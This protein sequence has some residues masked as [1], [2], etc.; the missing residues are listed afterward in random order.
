MKNL[1]KVLLVLSGL[2]SLVLFTACGNSTTAALPSTVCPAGESYVGNSCVANS[3][4]TSTIANSCAVSGEAYSA[5]LNECV[6][7][8]T[9]CSG[10]NGINPSTGQCVSLGGNSAG[11]A[12]HSPYE[13]TCQ[14]GYVQTQSGCLAQGQ[15]TLGYGFGYWGGYPYCFQATATQ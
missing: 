13:G 6:Q 5:N 8:T 15:C 11:T 7:Q 9:N 1:N 10:T 3:S 4:I 12:N 14:Y 2:S